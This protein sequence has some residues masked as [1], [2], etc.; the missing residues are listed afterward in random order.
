MDFK[1]TLATNGGDKL[2]HPY[3][4]LC[5]LFVQSV[6]PQKA[7]LFAFGNENNISTFAVTAN[8]GSAFR[9]MNGFSSEMLK[10]HTKENGTFNRSKKDF[11]P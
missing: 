4:P 8:G 9:F 7:L 3:T 2:S 1:N 5:A 10:A 11:V 6:L